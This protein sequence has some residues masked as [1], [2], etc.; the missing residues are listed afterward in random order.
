[1]SDSTY[2]AKST[3]S[4]FKERLAFATSGVV[5]AG[6]QSISGFYSAIT[7]ELNADYKFCM[8]VTGVEVVD[9]SSPGAVKYSDSCAG[10]LINNSTGT[11]C[12]KLDFV[13]SEN[14]TFPLTFKI[15]STIEGTYNHT[16][17]EVTISQESGIE[18]CEYVADGETS[19]C[20]VNKC[21]GMGSR[22]DNRT[23]QNIC[24]S[25]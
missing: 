6:N 15:K 5:D 12:G 17:A 19:S 23:Q 13:W 3:R 11:S 20:G 9:L 18:A 14:V 25:D 1:M 24:S 22:A 2:A 16:S 8:A 4:P 10:K 21:C 7:P